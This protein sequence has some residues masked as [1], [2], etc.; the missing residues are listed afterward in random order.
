MNKKASIKY[1]IFLIGLRVDRCLHPAVVVL[2]SLSSRMPC[3]TCSV[4]INE[5]TQV[6]FIKAAWDKCRRLERRVHVSVIQE[7]Y[8]NGFGFKL[9][10]DSN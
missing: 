6:R 8:W 9:Y 2:V 10:K 3:K 4:F 5:K 7:S 1:S